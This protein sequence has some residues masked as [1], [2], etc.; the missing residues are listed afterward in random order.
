MGDPFSVASSAIGVLSLGLTVCQVLVTYCSQVKSFK[1]E[2]D[3]VAGKA[4]SLKDV[5]SALLCLLSDA[6]AFDPSILDKVKL[7]VQLIEQC[8]QSVHR[9]EKMLEKVRNHPGPSSRK[10]EKAKEHLDRVL[11]PF[12]RDDLMSFGN[13]I[14]GL[15]VNLDLALGLLEMSVLNRILLLFYSIDFD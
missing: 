10:S 1:Q 9:L 15:K 6:A 5:L 4:N 7:A 8:G 13:T 11:Y 2:T 12:R 3:E 14:D